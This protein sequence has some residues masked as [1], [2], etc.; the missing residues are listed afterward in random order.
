[1]LYINFSKILHYR[2]LLQPSME[3]LTLLTEDELTEMM[4]NMRVGKAPRTDGFPA[5]F[6]KY[7][8]E[9]LRDNTF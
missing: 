1:M 3:A 4:K 6:Y 5:E 9:L 7:F 8:L 2:K